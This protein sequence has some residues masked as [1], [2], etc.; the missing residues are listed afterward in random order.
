M[1]N[2][3]INLILWKI[4]IVLLL[5]NYQIVVVI[6]NDIFVLK[7]LRDIL[8]L[9]FV[10]VSISTIKADFSYFKKFIYP[11][12]VF[13][14]CLIIGTWI[15]GN[16]GL[17]IMVLRRYIFPIGMF[18]S[19]L[20]FS[21]K[22]Q[23]FYNDM[24]KFVVNLVFILAIWGVF[25]AHVLH[26]TFLMNLGYPTIDNYT[27]QRET[28]NM[29]YYFGGLGIQRVTST[30]SNSNVFA[31]IC[32][33]SVIVAGLNYEEI[34]KSKFDIFKLSIIVLAY[35]LTVSRSNFLAMMIV[36]IVVM[37]KY[38]PDRRFIVKVIFGF[39]LFYFIVYI[40]QDSNGLS[41]RLL[42]WIIDSISFRE[43]S[44]AGRSVFW[45]A[46]F[47]RVIRSP[48]GIGF[49]NT[50]VIASMTGNLNFYVAENSYLSIALDTG[51][52]GL[53]SYVSFW[54]T[55]LWTTLKTFLSERYMSVKS[56]TIAILIYFMIVSFFSNH[57]YDMEAISFIY[58]IVAVSLGLLA[59]EQ[60]S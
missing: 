18:F 49:G 12:L 7:F 10:A 38:W 4:F 59:L 13:F 31:I 52:L 29:S 36:F 19:A 5:I 6:F 40:F 26:D 16:L 14:A 46:A 17:S 60:D 21:S 32:G 20:V 34:V 3:R 44:A 39:T 48:L 1:G 23:T 51:W 15:T 11:L 22:T 33:G 30:L 9:Y 8:L 25:Q 24:L 42:N 37:R 50:G 57:I 55:I 58:F 47:D 56:G 45:L 35:I 54:I 28:L 53:A 43:S 41:H 2:D 27:Y